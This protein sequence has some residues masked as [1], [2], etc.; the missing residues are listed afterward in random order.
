VRLGVTSGHVGAGRLPVSVDKRRQR[1]LGLSERSPLTT[2]RTMEQKE[3]KNTRVVTLL[4][5]QYVATDSDSRRLKL[6]RFLPFVAFA[7][8]C[9][10]S[11]YAWL[12]LE[13]LRV[14]RRLAFRFRVLPSRPWT[15]LFNDGLGDAR[16]VEQEQRLGRA[17][18]PKSNPNVSS[19]NCFQILPFF[20]AFRVFRG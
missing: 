19:S 13:N 5:I 15:I 18:T 6:G 14:T 7:T 2:V 1:W 17:L 11:L 3:T 4:Q 10:R 20:R 12:E 16:T 9:S 8:L